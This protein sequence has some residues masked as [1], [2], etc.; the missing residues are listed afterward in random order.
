MQIALQTDYLHGRLE[1]RLVAILD[2]S[3][4]FAFDP[5]VVYRLTDNLL[6]SA[7]YIAIESSRRAGL[8]NFRGHDMLQLRVQAQLN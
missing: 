3:G 7:T 4:I 2:V 8:G 1:P 6:L 5:S